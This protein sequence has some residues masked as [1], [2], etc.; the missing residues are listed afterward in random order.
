MPIRYHIDAESGILTVKW[1][2]EVS[3]QD[4]ARHWDTLLSDDAFPGISLA[5]TDLRESTF[6]FSSAEFW[7]T[8][9]NHYRDPIEL[10]PFKVAILVANENHERHVGIWRA[11]VPRTV[12][13]GLFHDPTHAAAWLQSDPDPEPMG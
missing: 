5:I 3:L 9:D 4:L 6:A 7:R 1:Q 8:I 2:G 12:T 11:L 10:K 13:V